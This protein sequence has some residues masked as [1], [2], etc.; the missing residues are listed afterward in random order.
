MVHPPV[1]PCGARATWYLYSGEQERSRRDHLL[2]LLG[3]HSAF[4][5][6]GHLHKYSLLVRTTPRGGRFLQLGLSSVISAPEVKPKNVLSG[7]NGYNGDQIN[8]E[9]SFSPATESQRRAVYETEAP[10]V[11]Q[12]EYADLTGYAVVTVQSKQVTA[13]IYSG[14]SRE[15]WRTLDLVKLLTS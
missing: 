15:V 12:F 7:V 2:E 6:S 10:Q 14:I 3:Q 5:L 4:V 9:P 11:K 1:V 8:V 13:R